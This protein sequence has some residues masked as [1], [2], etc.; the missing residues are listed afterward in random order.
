VAEHAMA[1]ASIGIAGEAAWLTLLAIKAEGNPKTE[2]AVEYEA[3]RERRKKE[4]EEKER[5]PV[6]AQ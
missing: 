3:D 2:Q 4:E 5:A 1:L 6:E